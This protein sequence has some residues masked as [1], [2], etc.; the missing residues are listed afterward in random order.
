MGEARTVSVGLGLIDLMIHD[1]IVSGRQLF[2]VD[3][4]LSRDF[5]W[6]GGGSERRIRRWSRSPP[7]A[8]TVD[9]R[10]DNEVSFGP[11]SLTSVGTDLPHTMDPQNPS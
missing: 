1:L 7:P 8:E 2:V 9:P 10:P 5:F 6:G 3:L 4:W 11:A